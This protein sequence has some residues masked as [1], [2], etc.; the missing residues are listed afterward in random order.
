MSHARENPRSRE[1]LETQYTNYVE[2]GHNAFEFLVDFGRS[3]PEEEEAAFHTRIVTSPS[4]AKALF[5]LLRDSIDQYEKTFGL[6]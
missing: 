3:S 4:C 1:H 2:V 5:E 6:I